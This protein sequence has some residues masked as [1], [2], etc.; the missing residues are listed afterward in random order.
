MFAAGGSLG[1]FRLL[2]QVGIA[3]AHGGKPYPENLAVVAFGDVEY[4]A[5]LFAVGGAPGF[6]VNG[7][8]HFALPAYGHAVVGSHEDN[9]EVGFAFADNVF[10]VFRPVEVVRSAEAG[11]EFGG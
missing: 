10:H 5:H 3:S 1:D 7:V 2:E 11:G 8:L 6:A 4:L 9:D